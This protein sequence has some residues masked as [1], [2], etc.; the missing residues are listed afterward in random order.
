MLADSAVYDAVESKTGQ[1][2]VAQLFQV[3]AA[4]PVVVSQNFQLTRPP[5]INASSIQGKSFH[6]RFSLFFVNSLDHNLSGAIR[7]QRTAR[8]T[9]WTT[10][11]F[12]A[13][14][15]NMIDMMGCTVLETPSSIHD[16]VTR[17]DGGNEVTISCNSRGSGVSLAQS[18]SGCTRGSSHLAR[19][20]VRPQYCTVTKLCYYTVQYNITIREPMRTF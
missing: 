4:T 8:Q 14:S 17:R 9:T 7:N 15:V 13:C 6:R 12:L 5:S 19:D 18:H 11:S 10:S 20:G 2:C 16:T 3:S 1:Q